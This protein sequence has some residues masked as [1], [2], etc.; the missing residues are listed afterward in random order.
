MI[1]DPA[2]IVEARIAAGEVLDRLTN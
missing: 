1:R 2:A